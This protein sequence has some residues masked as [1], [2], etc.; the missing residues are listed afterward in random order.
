M[1]IAKVNGINLFYEVHGQGKPLVLILGLSSDIS[2]YG[3]IINFLSKSYKVIVS[4]NRGAGRSDKPRTK[5]SMD[6]MADDIIGLLDYLKINQVYV[7]GTSM[8]GRIALSLALNHKT[9]VKKLILVCTFA[10]RGHRVKLS[11]PTRLIYP[12]RYLPPFRGKYPQPRYA[13][14]LQ[15]QATFDFNVVSRL[16]EIKQPTLILHGKKDKTVDY[17]FAEVLNKKIKGSKLIPFK[18][19]HLFFMFFERQKFLLAVTAWLA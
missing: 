11:W 3:F 12:F 10:A 13:Y 5:Y 4:D 17:S 18:G 1:P 8:G 9:R 7:L 6:Q 14:I 19:G 2:D 15:R 16:G